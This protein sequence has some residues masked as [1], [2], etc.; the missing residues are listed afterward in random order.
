MLLSIRE[1]TISA[2]LIYLFMSHIKWSRERH[3]RYAIGIALL[4]HN[5]RDYWKEKR[6]EVKVAQAPLL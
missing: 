6:S 2:I 3:I 1:Y 4:T 5:Y